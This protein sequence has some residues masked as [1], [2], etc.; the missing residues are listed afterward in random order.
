MRRRQGLLLRPLSA[1]PECLL[2][3]TVYPY[4]LAAATSA[5]CHGA[6]FATKL[7]LASDFEDFSLTFDA[8]PDPETLS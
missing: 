3:V 6:P 7:K 1:R 8:D 5:A 2:S 4:A